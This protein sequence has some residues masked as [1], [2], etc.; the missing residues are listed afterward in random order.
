MHAAPP[1]PAP[2]H[3][4][5]QLPVSRAPASPFL[6]TDPPP[7]PTLYLSLC[8]PRHTQY[9]KAEFQEA[10]GSAAE[11][12]VGSITTLGFITAEH[13]VGTQVCSATTGNATS[14]AVLEA[15]SVSGDGGLWQ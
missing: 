14:Q 10:C 7:P 15:G 8:S 2:P 9:N 4:T 3:R 12:K 11:C 13:G 1:H 5:P 6:P